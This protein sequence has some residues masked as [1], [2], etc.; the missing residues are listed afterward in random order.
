MC[1]LVARDFH[2]EQ[3]VCCEVSR[4]ST[5]GGSELVCCLDVDQEHEI[6]IT[7]FRC[8]LLDVEICELGIDEEH[9]AFDI[10]HR[11]VAE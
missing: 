4:A 10:L 1:S 7:Q 2:L 8:W 9:G 6:G 11:F 5:L 3:L